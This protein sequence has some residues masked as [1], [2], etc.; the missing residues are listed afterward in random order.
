MSLNTLPPEIQNDIL[1]EIVL[2]NSMIDSVFHIRRFL[3]LGITPYLLATRSA[4]E[5]WRASR[6]LIL[7]R[8]A[9][10]HLP[11]A[12][13]DRRNL[14]RAFVRARLRWVIWLHVYYETQQIE[15]ED[16]LEKVLDALDYADLARKPLKKKEK[17]VEFWR[18]F[19]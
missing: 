17:V 9:S 19:L 5:C 15:R 3:T 7:R 2:L 10:T 12:E 13:I 11:V 8:V 6:H 14:R 4:H 16:L 1:Y 18:Q